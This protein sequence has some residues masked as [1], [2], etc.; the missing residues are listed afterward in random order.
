MGGI[1]ILLEGGGGD[2]WGNFSRCGEMSKILG[3]GKTPPI[4]LVGKTLWGGVI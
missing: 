3:G 2:G 4:P 1:K